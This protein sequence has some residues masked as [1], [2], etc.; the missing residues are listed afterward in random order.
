MEDMPD[1][2]IKTKDGIEVGIRQFNRKMND[3]DA[4]EDVPNFDSLS[5]Y[6]FSDSSDISKDV[7]DSIPSVSFNTNDMKGSS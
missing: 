6:S 2:K 1:V 4:I 5:Q 7:P 3:H